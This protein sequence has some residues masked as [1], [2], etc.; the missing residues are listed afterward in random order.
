MALNK[1]KHSGR[2]KASIL[3]LRIWAVLG[4]FALFLVAKKATETNITLLVYDFTEHILV[5]PVLSEQ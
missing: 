2:F 3:K 4:S 1:Y 5:L